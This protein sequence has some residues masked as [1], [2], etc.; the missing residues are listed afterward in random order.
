MLPV[1]AAMRACQDPILAQHLSRF[2]KTG[3]GQYAEGDRFLGLK[4]PHTRTFLPYCQGLTLNQL[5][6]LLHSPFHEE[7]LLAL[8]ALSR[9][10][11]F[12]AEEVYQLYCL[13][14]AFVNNWDLVDSS[15]APIV[16]KYLLKRS[17]EQLYEWTRS[18]SLWERRIS[19]IATFAFL[20]KGDFSDS[21]SI[22]QQLLG[23][24]H[25]LIH[26]ACGWV[27][28]ELG[29]REQPLLIEFLDRNSPSMAAVCL[30][31]ACEHLAPE[32][33]LAFRQKRKSKPRE[34]QS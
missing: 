26:K 15:A 29:K 4:V 16:G 32:V 25:D 12:S 23:D 1:Q 11:R 8:L 22:C 33:R 30:S 5:Q 24:P 14:T 17:R 27:L 34:T 10:M 21:L 13:N 31:Y 7:R 19:I 9:R 28:R 2:F 3:P 20:R 18:E 6:E